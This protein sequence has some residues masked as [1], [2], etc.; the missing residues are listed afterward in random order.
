VRELERAVE[1]FVGFG[2]FPEEIVAAMD[3]GRRGER[4]SRGRT[5]TTVRWARRGDL[6]E[7][8]QAIERALAATGG[9]VGRA[10]RLLGVHPNTV[11]RVRDTS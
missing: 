7:R 2:E 1:E 5:V 8:R 3:G 10:A 9:H 4:A 6:E 11:R